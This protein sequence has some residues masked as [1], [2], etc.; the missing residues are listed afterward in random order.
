MKAV[1]LLHVLM[2]ISDSCSLCLLLL[3]LSVC[4]W[5]PAADDQKERNKERKALRHL[6]ISSSRRTED[7]SRIVCGGKHEKEVS[8]LKVGNARKRS[9]NTSQSSSE[10]GLSLRGNT[11]S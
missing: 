11:R 2:V 5:P 1:S 4:S 8:G 7:E 3:L 6:L 10:A 9:D